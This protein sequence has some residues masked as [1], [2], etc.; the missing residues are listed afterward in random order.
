[1]KFAHTYSIPATPFN[2]NP[3]QPTPDTIMV[4]GCAIRVQKFPEGR[5]EDIYVDSEDYPFGDKGH[6]PD[7]DELRDEGFDYS[8]PFGN[9]KW[10]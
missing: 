4:D 2:A 10:W 1:M 5:A 7:A 3:A 6:G 9:R 8:T